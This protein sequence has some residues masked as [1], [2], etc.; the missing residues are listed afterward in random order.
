[1]SVRFPLILLLLSLTQPVLAHRV[2]TR[3]Y[4]HRQHILAANVEYTL[5]SKS[6]IHDISLAF[7]MT[8]ALFLFYLGWRGERHRRGYL[9][10]FYAALGF[11]VARWVFRREPVPVAD[12]VTRFR[13]SG[14]L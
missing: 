9:L 6:V 13:I 7:F 11:A 4:R 5:L 10:S 12:P 2:I 1:M 3:G 8:L 14:L